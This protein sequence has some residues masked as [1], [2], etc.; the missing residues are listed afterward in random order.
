MPDIVDGAAWPLRGEV[1]Q[2]LG[3]SLV[4]LVICVPAGLVLAWLARRLL[5]RK[6]IRRLDDAAPP[7][8]G[9]SR[10]AVSVAVGAFSHL[11]FDFVSHGGCR[12]LWPWYVN[13]R[14]FPSW[15]YHR[16]GGIPLPIYR[17][18][19]PFAPHTVMWIVLTVVV[20]VLFVRCLR[21]S[22]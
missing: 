5:S 9:R 15:W 8:A 10:A 11:L 20:A 21:R 22:S 2:W 1:G 19:Y 14:L 12:F 17:E 13:D 6:W 18:P 3:H 7:R 16:W 4:G